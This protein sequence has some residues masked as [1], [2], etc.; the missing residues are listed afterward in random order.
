MQEH[1]CL[2]LH[3]GEKKYKYSDWN[4]TVITND[5]VMVRLV[6]LRG[7]SRLAM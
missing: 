3:N 4:F 7:I 2:Y 1:A 6:V 5:R